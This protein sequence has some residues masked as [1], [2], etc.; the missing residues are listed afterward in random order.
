MKNRLLALTALAALAGPARGDEPVT[1]NQHVAPILWRLCAGCHHAG[2]V[3]PFPLMTYKDASRRARFIRDITASQRMPPWRAGHGYGPFAN[4]RRLSDAELRTLARWVE[5]GAP[6]GDPKDL[7]PAPTF[8]EGWQLGRPD[9][10]LKMPAVF[11]VP[12]TGPDV[13]RCFVLP[14]PVRADKMVTAVEFHPGNRRVIHHAS[15]FLDDKGQG[16][17]RET[18]TKDGQRGYSSFGGPGFAPVG[19]L[20]GWGLAALP[21]FF[22]D[23][24]GMILP[25]GCDL[26]L[27]I[28]YHPTGK[29]ETDQSELGIYFCKKPATKF[30]TTLS[31][32]TTDIAIP[33]GAKRFRVACESAPLP[34]DVT[35]LTVTPHMHFLGRQISATARLPGGAKRPLIGITD[36]NFH[37]HERYEF[38]VPLRLPKGTVIEVDAFYDNS[39]DNPSNP[40]SP[41][42]LV[43]Y[44]NNLTDEMVSCHLEVVADSPAEL[45][46]LVNMRGP[47]PP[48]AKTGPVPRREEKPAK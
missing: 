39:A 44:G 11:R 40:N 6:E 21:R 9:L 7:R 8:P 38:K 27:Q 17:K 15:F 12:A 10:I 2:A 18:Q 25:K 35:V 34:A 19:S 28:H 31:T 26:V 5:G 45:R 42:R 41:P 43:R 23:G 4:E 14:L 16:R 46:E 37:W 22:P 32:R 36:W 29:E 3:G 30:V 47:G 20:G 33:A 13:Y 1:F 48:G 24:A